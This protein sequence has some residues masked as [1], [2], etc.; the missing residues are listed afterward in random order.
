M[1]KSRRSTRALQDARSNKEDTIIE[2]SS[3]RSKLT[4]SRRALGDVSNNKSRNGVAFDGNKFMDMA[5]TEKQS[6]RRSRRLSNVNFTREDRN[7]IG[8]HETKTALVL[9]PS[10]NPIS[11]RGQS[12]DIQVTTND[13]RNDLLTTTKEG[14]TKNM[15]LPSDMDSKPEATNANRNTHKTKKRNNEESFDIESVLLEPKPRRKRLKAKKTKK[16]SRMTKEVTEKSVELC[17]LKMQ[18]LDA[19]LSVLPS[20]TT[21]LNLTNCRCSDLLKSSDDDHCLL[22]KLEG[23]F[24]ASKFTT[25]ISA[26][27]KEHEGNVGEVPAYVTDIFQRLFDAE[28]ITRPSP[29]YMTNG[30]HEINS[31]M[32]AILVDWLVGVQ[33]KFRLQPE[34]LYLCVNIIDRYLSRT[35]V[36]RRRLQLLGVTALFVACKYEEIYPLEVKDCVYVTDRAFNRQDVIDMEFD[37][38]MVL[39]FKMTVP[40]AYPFL[41][42]FLHITNAPKMIRDLASFYT[43]RMLQEYCMLN[44][45]ASMLA[46][47]AVCL[48]WNNPTAIEDF[49]EDGILDKLPKVLDMIIK[50]T[51]FCEKE[52]KH[53]ASVICGKIRPQSNGGQH[54]RPTTQLNKVHVKYRSEGY[55]NVSCYDLPDVNHLG[56]EIHEDEN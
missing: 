38:V 27:D 26:F 54:G 11:E 35:S 4:R 42:R 21:D 6:L 29:S 45:R 10:R 52:I 1:L 50:Y 51:G 9:V 16:E 2:E 17:G 53:T 12:S 24:D 55:S 25:G 37:I 36:R 7:P 41:Q 3:P 31:T 14:V 34:T 39:G 44:F 20:S 43:E 19:V 5:P 40:T 46:S 32:R 48:A 30:Q 47:A 8:E 23:P 56:L 18:T 28:K 33:M 22:R 13:D 15:Q 49:E